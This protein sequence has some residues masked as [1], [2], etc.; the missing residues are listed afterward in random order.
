MEHK[1]SAS[2]AKIRC[3]IYIFEDTMGI[4]DPSSI[5]NTIEHLSLKIKKIEVRNITPPAES[6]E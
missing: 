3:S 1:K 5:N 6:K 4:N 2:K